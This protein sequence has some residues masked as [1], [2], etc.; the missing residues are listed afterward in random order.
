MKRAVKSGHQKR[1]ESKRKALEQ[2]ANAPG[3]LS[4]LE[5]FRSTSTNSSTTTNTDSECI[6]TVEEMPSE[7]MEFACEK[8]QHVEYPDPVPVMV[9]VESDTEVKRHQSKGN[10]KR[11][12][13]KL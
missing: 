10:H 13:S 4:L 3:Q 1:V 11:F 7:I 2:S 6:D 8:S 9:V 5:M 12:K